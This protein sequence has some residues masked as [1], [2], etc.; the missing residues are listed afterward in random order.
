MGVEV[1]GVDVWVSYVIITKVMAAVLIQNLGVNGRDGVFAIN[2]QVW[3]R[4]R[5]VHQV[6][7]RLLRGHFHLGDRGPS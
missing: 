7:R 2:P 1:L 3:R 5:H 6:L 4:H